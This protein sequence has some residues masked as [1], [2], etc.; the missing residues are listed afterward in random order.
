MKKRSPDSRRKPSKRKRLWMRRKNALI[1]RGSRLPLQNVRMKS[2]TC[3][4]SRGA[5]TYGKNQTL[6]MN[7]ERHRNFRQHCRVLPA[8]GA[9]GRNP[10]LCNQHL[11][12]LQGKV[13]KPSERM[14][15]LRRLYRVRLR[16]AWLVHRRTGN[17]PDFTEMCK[18]ADCIDSEHE[19][20]NNAREHRTQRQEKSD[21]LHSHRQGKRSPFRAKGTPI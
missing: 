5:T 13:M 19:K 21:S 20:H 12:T 9:F 8:L 1:T 3:L 16:A 2:E 14:Q 6:V 10:G 4:K 18:I 11:S 15:N 7:N 17:R